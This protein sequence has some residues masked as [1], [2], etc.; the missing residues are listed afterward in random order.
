MPLKEQLT[1]ATYNVHKCVGTDRIHDAERI[2]DII[3]ALDADVIG[4]QE[5]ES[6]AKQETEPLA[7]LAERTRYKVIRGPTIRQPGRSYGNLLL[8]RQRV[9][10]T[11]LINISV[12]GREPRGVIDAVLEI[13]DHTVRIMVTHLGLTLGERRYQAE[14]LLDI[15]Q[16]MDTPLLIVMGDM[17]EWHPFN[18]RIR[19]LQRWMGRSPAPFTFPARFPFLALDRIWVRPRHALIEMQAYR[20][21]LARCASDHLPL[22]ATVSLDERTI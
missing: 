11:H 2:A 9:V 10:Q 7:V 4:L 20:S 18:Q 8:T 12:P 19:N 6:G 13:A 16:S 5:V 22:R 3:C 15:V 14:R 17:N 21:P 1:V